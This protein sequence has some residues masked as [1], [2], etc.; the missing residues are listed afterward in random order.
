M[1]FGG[2][3]VGG[4]QSEVYVGQLFYSF[5]SL[6]QA[7][8]ETLSALMTTT[9]FLDHVIAAL[10]HL[11]LSHVLMDEFGYVNNLYIILILKKDSLFFLLESSSPLPPPTK[12][13]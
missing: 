7:I 13:T 8:K 3:E 1:I 4:G 9:T 5:H 12:L 10:A 6:C 2:G 11:S